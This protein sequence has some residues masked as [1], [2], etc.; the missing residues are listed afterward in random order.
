MNAK[1]T[2]AAIISRDQLQ[3]MRISNDLGHSIRCRLLKSQ[4]LLVSALAIG[5]LHGVRRVALPMGRLGNV[6]SDL[7]KA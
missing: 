6:V 4:K 2:I 7:P 1:T 3:G 5:Y